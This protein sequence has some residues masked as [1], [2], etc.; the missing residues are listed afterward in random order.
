MAKHGGKRKG[1]GR[2]PLTDK[3]KGITI[4]PLESQ[5]NSCG[6]EEL[7]KE[8]AMKAIARKA[9]KNGN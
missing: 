4:Y 8:L 5:I 2:K 6:G 7:C 1:S 9:L 3:K